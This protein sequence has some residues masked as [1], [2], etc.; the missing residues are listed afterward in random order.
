MSD[1]LTLKN[2]WIE[3]WS[4]C[5]VIVWLKDPTEIKEFMTYSKSDVVKCSL[6][7]DDTERRP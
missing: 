3:S 5:G 7:W 4:F 6:P 2:S 1:I